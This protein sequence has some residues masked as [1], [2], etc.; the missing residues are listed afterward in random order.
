[1]EEAYFDIPQHREFAQLE[2][3]ACLPDES[4]I[5]RF[6]YRLKQPN[7]AEKMLATAPA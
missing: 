5:L 3:F 6:R 1:M 2:E 7:L 4:T